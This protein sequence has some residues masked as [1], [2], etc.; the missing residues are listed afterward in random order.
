MGA[1]YGL[2]LTAHVVYGLFF[3]LTIVCAG[4]GVFLYAVQLRSQ[5]R[6]ATILVPRATIAR[7]ERT[8]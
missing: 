6:A 3:A 4:R 8:P 5:V 7:E 2:L 1:T